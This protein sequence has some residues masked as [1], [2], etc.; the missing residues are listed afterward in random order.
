ME[1]FKVSP[2][3]PWFKPE[4]GW[5]DKIPTNL[6]FP[7]KTVDRLVE[8]A[9]QRW[10]DKL[11]ARFLG[12]EMTYGEYNK[13]VNKFASSLAQLGLK[14]SETVAILLPN[15]FQ[16]MIAYNAVLRVGGI[17]SA[18]NPTYKPLEIKHQME[19]VN[20][21]YLI[22]LDVLYE[23]K[24]KPIRKDLNLKFIIGSNI[25]DFLPWFKKKLG[26]FLKK[27]PSAKLPPESMQF[28]E[29]LKTNKEPPLVRVD[30]HKDAAVYIMTGGTTGIPKAAIL[31]HFNLYSNAMQIL[32]WFFKSQP[33]IGNLGILP[34]FHAFGMTTIL[35]LTPLFGG[36]IHLFPKPPKTPELLKVIQNQA[37]DEGFIFIG[38]EV[39]FQ[40]VAD[41]EDLENFDIEGKLFLNV[42]GAGPLHKDVQE[43]YEEKTNAPLVEGYGLTEAGPVVTVN[44]LWCDEEQRRSGSIGLPLPG[45]EI[46][47]VHKTDYTKELELTDDPEDR[48]NIGELAVAGPQVMLGYLNNDQETNAHIFE[49]DDKRWLLTGDIGYMN[50]LGQVTILDRKK[51]LIKYKGYSVFPKDVENLIGRHEAVNEIAVAGLPDED[52]TEVIKAWIVLEK[53]FEGKIT[54]EDIISWCKENITHYK[55]PAHIEFIDEIPKNL[56]GKVLRR[57]LRENDPI[58]KNY[59]LEHEN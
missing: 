14:K 42:S 26:A 20:A 41:F 52:T 59:F 49:K 55:V 28:T 45:T 16:F 40:R 24:I 4:S 39:L 19:I 2:D 11:A 38:A 58:W 57:V 25:G 34:F 43:R 1:E 44:P 8:D 47:I 37:P 33:G 17:I 53:E 13:K 35:N 36:Y 21:S 46:K 29:L 32:A 7:V 51:E 15:S 23:D 10:P 5:E 12:E 27:L 18:I 31:S 48:E 3:K 22:Y 30:P 54:E 56:V 50:H 9:A 6:E